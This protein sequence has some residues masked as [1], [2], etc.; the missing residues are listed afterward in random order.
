[1]RLVGPVLFLALLAAI[2]YIGWAFR[3]VLFGIGYH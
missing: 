2:A 3:D 1:M